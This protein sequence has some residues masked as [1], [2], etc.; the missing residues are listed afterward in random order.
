MFIICFTQLKRWASWDRTKRRNQHRRARTFRSLR[1]ARAQLH[2]QHHQQLIKEAAQ[3][4]LHIQV[5]TRHR[6]TITRWKR[7]IWHTA[8]ALQDLQVLSWVQR[9]DPIWIRLSPHITITINKSII[10][11]AMTTSCVIITI[12]TWTTRTFMITTRPHIP[13]RRSR[14]SSLLLLF[15][16]LFALLEF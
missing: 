12:T 13:I 10:M 4:E 5:P 3:V 1:Q 11:R 7:H 2:V 6:D 14:F 9:T 15:Y 16:F 8:R